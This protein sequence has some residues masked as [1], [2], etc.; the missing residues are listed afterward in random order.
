MDDE[1]VLQVT[2]ASGWTAT[3]ASEARTWAVSR[4]SSTQ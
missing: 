1:L 2:M 3:T 4:L